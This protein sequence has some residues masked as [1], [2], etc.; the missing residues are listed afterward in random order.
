MAT[1]ARVDAPNAA[2]HQMA[3]KWK[4]IHALVGGTAV[5]RA[6]RTDWLPMEPKE[7]YEAY[8]RRLGRSVLFNALKDTI[9]KLTAKP[10][11]VPIQIKGADALPDQLAAIEDDA[12]MNGCTLT[13]VF[14]DGFWDKLEHG[15]THYLVDYPQVGTGLNLLQEREA[16]IR[17]YI[18]RVSPRDLIGWRSERAANGRDVLTQIRVKETRTEPVGAW[19]DAEV[20]Y[21]RVYTRNTWEIHRRDPDS[22]EWALVDSGTHTFGAIPLV[23]DY[24][25]RTG[26]LTAEPPFEDLAW[27][28]LDHWQKSSD[29][30]NILHHAR[31][32]MRFRKGFSREELDKPMVIGAGSDVGT[33][34]PNA[35]FKYVE[36]QGAAIQHGADDLAKIEERMQ[37]LGSQPLIEAASAKTA[38]EAGIG[39]S[40]NSASIQSWI[41][42]SEGAAE[43]CYR[44]A[45]KWIGATLPDDFGIDIYSDFV[46]SLR[47][48]DDV[49]AILNLMAQGQLSSE[50]GLRELK[51]RGVLAETVDIAM[52]MDAVAAAAPSFDVTEEPVAA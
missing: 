1:D 47:A 52:E 15:L 14:R 50:T 27:L 21:I 3:D 41:R 28:N 17:P 4:L 25:R 8:E 33:T 29:Q 7:S 6:A 5:M 26:V 42:G 45:A 37:V 40:R 43:K 18:V 39:E 35:D 38:T 9:N 49:N 48:A 31:V 24:T 13:A 2:Y 12:D 10:F 22:K 23:T 30:S 19:G 11:S 36:P 32:P 34:N 16:G 44:L 51:R 20:Q 46:T